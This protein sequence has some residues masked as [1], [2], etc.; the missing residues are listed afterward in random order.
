MK[1]FLFSTVSDVHI[2]EN[3]LAQLGSVL[4]GLGLKKILLVTDPGIEKAGLLTKAIKSMLVNNIE[5]C[6]YN[7]VQADP[8]DEIIKHAQ[9]RYLA[10]KCD[11]VVGFG[12]GSSMDVAKVL[13]VLAMQ[14]QELGD[15]YGVDNISSKRVPLVQIPTTAGTGSEATM[16]SVVTTGATTKS[17]IVSRSLLA[18]AI[19]LDPNLT[20]GLPANITA[21]TGIDAMVHAIESYTSARL[22]NPVSDMLAKEA[23]RLL[24]GAIHT[25]VND[26]TNISARNDMLLGAMFAG[27]AF[28]NAPVA[29]VHALAYPLGGFYHIPHGLSNSLVLPQVLKFNGPAAD[30]LYSELLPCISDIQTEKE[31]DANAADLMASYFLK[32]AEDLNIPSSLREMNIPE[33]DMEML[34]EAGMQQQRLLINNPREVKYDDALAIYQAAY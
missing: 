2:G 3:S 4:Q 24:S 10:E 14:E 11:G 1:P 17:G 34:A 18:D 5:Y 27:Q 8:S 15:I 33:N 23:L 6:L 26:G 32:L 13:A 30:S 19:I 28:A 7:Q 9:S 31:S 22:K 25:A 20:V 21:Y 12:G 29:A 16:V